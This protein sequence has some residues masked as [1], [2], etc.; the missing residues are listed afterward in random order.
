M[1][2]FVGM[3]LEDEEVSSPGKPVFVCKASRIATLNHL[4]VD[5]HSC[6]PNGPSGK[7]VTF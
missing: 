4:V 5:P 2:M 1:H 7:Y 3:L 6:C